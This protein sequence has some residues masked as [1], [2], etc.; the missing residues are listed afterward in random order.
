MIHAPGYNYNSCTE[1]CIYIYEDL[2]Y[3]IIITVKSNGIKNVKKSL[4]VLRK[5]PR[6]ILLCLITRLQMNCSFQIT[7]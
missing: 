6:N 3:F 7:L 5:L 1:S 2:A 4:A